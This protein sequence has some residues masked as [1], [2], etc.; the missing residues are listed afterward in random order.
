MRGRDKLLETI[1]GVPLLR[2]QAQAAR[3]VSDCVLVAL[4][5][6]PHPRYAVITDLDVVPINV[7]DAAEAMGASIRTAFAAL[8]K[9]TDKAM[10]LLADLPEI[11]PDDLRTVIATA[12]S[13][14]Q[15]L[16]WRGATEDGKAG[17]PIVFDHRLFPDLTQLAGD[18]GGQEIVKAAGNRVHLVRLPGQRARLDL[19]TP[20]DW[21]AWRAGRP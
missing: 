17:H 12:Q 16:I 14:P 4:P 5:P 1:D 15:A 19:D 18:G 3:A 7:P 13:H 11:T 10:L 9:G 6:R 21:D 20:E 2:R 8:P